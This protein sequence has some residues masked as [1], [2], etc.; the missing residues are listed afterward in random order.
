MIANNHASS[1]DRSVK[2]VERLK[3]LLKGHDEKIQLGAAEEVAFFPMDTIGERGEMQLTHRR[4]V[5]EMQSG[6]TPFSNDDVLVAKITPCF[7]NGKGAVVRNLIP[8]LGFGTT[9]LHVLSPGPR[10]DPNF[11]Y[12]VTASSAFRIKGEASMTGAAGQKRVPTDFVK[13]F[14]VWCPEL[15]CQ[16]QIVSH[17]ERELAELD[18]LV[19]EKRRMMELLN[20]KRTA[21]ITRA[22]TRGLDPAAVLAD[23]SLNWVEGIP[24]TWHEPRFK[25]I[26]R[27]RDERSK[28]GDEE[29]LSV[30]HITGVTPRSEKKVYMFKAEDMTG[31]KK[32]FSGDLVVNTL[33]A[34]MGALGIAWREGIVSPDYHVYKMS[35]ELLPKYVD[36]VCRSEPF[37]VQILRHSKGVW[38]SRLRLYP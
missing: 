20:E 9:E 22:V 7:E 17:L 11:L 12:Y 28:S 1:S 35:D 26:V 14:P 13:N 31:Y 8:N 15:R 10:I 24:Q 4:P 30:S 32:C 23:S 29:L 21:T 27:I 37:K 36:L 33:W 2:G 38:S 18:D 16:R 34:F 5:E 6:F 3:Y 25:Q 19:V